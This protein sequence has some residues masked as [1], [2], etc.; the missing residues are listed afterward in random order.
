P[1]GSVLAVGETFG[2]DNIQHFA[3][4]RLTSTGALDPSFGI[5]G[6]RVIDFGGPYGAAS[7]VALQSDG[8]V[9]MVGYSATFDSYNY[10]SDFA[11][12]RLNSAGQ[13]DTSFSGSG[14][15]TIDFGGSNG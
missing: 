13:L 1:D 12:V 4:V 5:G 7:G 8:S 2:A 15:Q 6:K 3:A 10:H 11:V 14:K 9:G